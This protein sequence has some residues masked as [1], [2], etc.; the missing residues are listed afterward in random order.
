[1]SHQEVIKKAKITRFKHNDKISLKTTFN[2][3]SKFFAFSPHFPSIKK[4]KGKR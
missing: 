3:L 1:M 4:A 2:N